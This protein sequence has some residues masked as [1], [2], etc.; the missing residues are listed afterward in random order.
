MQ[1]GSPTAEDENRGGPTLPQTR[2]RA[3]IHELTRQA[4]PVIVA[5]SA[6]ML[7]G[8][9]DAIMVGRYAAEELAVLGL[10]LTLVASLLLT[11]IGLM[12]GTLVVTAMC[13]GRGDLTAC[14][15]VW[16]RSL[17]YAC[18]LGLGMGTICA[19]ADPILRALGQAPDLAA[20]AAPVVAVLGLGLLPHLVSVATQFFLE[21]IKRPVPGM[22]VMIIA[23]VLNVALNWV[24]IYGHLGLPAMG[25]LGS[26]WATT[27]VRILLAA[28]AVLFVLT[29]ADR[30]L[31]LA[32]DA[33]ASP[34][35]ARLQRRLGYASGL[36]VGAEGMA[37]N[38]LGLIAGWLG[39]MPLAAYTIGF[40]LVAFVFMVAVGFGAA[41]AVQVGAAAGRDD[42]HEARLAGWTGLAMA[43]MTMALIALVIALLPAPI[44]AV[45]TDDAILAGIAAPVIAVVALV[46]V[47]DGAQ[48]VMAGA[49]RGLGDTWVAS[50]LHAGAFVFIMVPS[51]WLAAVAGGRGPVGL[52]EGMLLGCIAAWAVL[53]WRFHR[54]TT[55][56][57]RGGALSSGA[58]LG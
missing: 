28:M 3:R 29:M 17:L 30:H 6:I 36:S 5:R 25:A 22:L 13:H 48:G 31:Y 52:F 4:G 33:L 10:A 14:G 46:V 21:G 53:A 54:L 16:R 39:A 32:T 1:I 57:T 51:A 43:T 42:R 24:L 37:F 45:Y 34:P 44:V 41:T 55:M 15:I 35:P 9:V 23:N 40:N 18:V 11:G 26:A 56:P 20:Q 27:I 19:F 7:M 47:A 12:M 58:R 50:G 49:V 2:A 38:T 8:L